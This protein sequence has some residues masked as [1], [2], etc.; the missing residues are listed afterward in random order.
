MLGDDRRGAEWG[1]RLTMRVGSGTWSLEQIERFLD[2][3]RIPVR[4]ACVTKSGSPIILSLW[5]RYEEGALWCATQAN[6]RV[7]HHLRHDPRCAF[8]IAADAPP[9]RGVRGRGRATIVREPVRELLPRLIARYLGGADSELARWL[10]RRIDKE[11]AIRIDELR[12][13]TWDFSD[14]M[15]A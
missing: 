13:S 12:V 4:L 8:E 10:L 5:F 14:R 1:R 2:E 11:V 9:Y 6:A 15:N 7:V 3:A